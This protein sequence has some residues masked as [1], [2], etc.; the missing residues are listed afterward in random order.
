MHSAQRQYLGEIKGFNQHYP[1]KS[2]VNYHYLICSHNM[3][4]VKLRYVQSFYVINVKNTKE[5]K[6]VSLI[7]RC[8]SL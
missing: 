4:I 5:V 2:E 7:K 8:F 3:F 6:N 1:G